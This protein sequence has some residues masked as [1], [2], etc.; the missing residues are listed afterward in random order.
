M[1]SDSVGPAT[2][3]A[4]RSRSRATRALPDIVKCF[5]AKWRT[6]SAAT[7]GGVDDGEWPSDAFA[8]NDDLAEPGPVMSRSGRAARRVLP[9]FREGSSG[10]VAEAAVER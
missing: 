10:R 7:W 2:L 8:V 5:T 1:G 9:E 6:A 4:A 3:S